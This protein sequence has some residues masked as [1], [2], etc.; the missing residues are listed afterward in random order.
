MERGPT[1]M[2]L[3]AQG[4]AIAAFGLLVGLPLGVLAGREGWR[5][6]ANRVPLDYVPPFSVVPLV[7][8]VPAAILIVNGLAVWPSR[9]VGRLHPAEDLRTECERRRRTC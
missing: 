1:Q 2:I 3:N 9:R 5:W 8:S 4:T 6:V 7:A